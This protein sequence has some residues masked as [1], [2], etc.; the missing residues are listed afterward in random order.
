MDN[1]LLLFILIF[2]HFYFCL[3]FFTLFSG[4]EDIHI[5]VFNEFDVDENEVEEA[6]N[7]YIN[8][9]NKELKKINDGIRK[10]FKMFGGDIDEDDEEE[11]GSENEDEDGEYEDMD[12]EVQ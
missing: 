9:G 2:C 12:E 1:F 7:Y 11:E 3:Y 10:V 5:S 4:F 6:V 8:K